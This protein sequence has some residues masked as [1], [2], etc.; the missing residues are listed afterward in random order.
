M[1]AAGRNAGDAGAVTVAIRAIAAECVEGELRAPT[2]LGVRVANATIDYIYVDT[3]A[4]RAVGKGAV[5]RHELLVDAIE[6]PTHSGF[7]AELMD[8]A[9]LHDAFDVGIV[10]QA[11]DVFI[12]DGGGEAVHHGS[13]FLIHLERLAERVAMDERLRGGRTRLQND[14]VVALD[15]IRGWRDRGSF[16]S[17][18]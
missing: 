10:A 3:G 7:G 2:E 17:G 4:G 14:D 6:R 11:V 12:G 9:I 18:R 15:D 13:E 1:H 5:E 16:R 8:V